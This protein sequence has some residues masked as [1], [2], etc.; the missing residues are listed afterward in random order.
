MPTRRNSPRGRGT[1]ARRP[2]HAG[3]PCV[4]RRGSFRVRRRSR[5][6]SAGPL[7]EGPGL[8]R[9]V[10]LSGGGTELPAQFSC[11]RRALRETCPIWTRGWRPAP[12]SRAVTLGRRRHL[13]AQRENCARCRSADSNLPP[14][15]RR[16]G[17]QG[18]SGAADTSGSRCTPRRRHG[19]HRLPPGRLHA[20]V[21]EGGGI[22]NR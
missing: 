4:P 13:V 17:Y 9:H 3:A 2:Y 15:G 12:L 14:C 5:S 6:S 7:R 16:R 10:S 22:G 1:V 21:G 8:L 20:D 18:S 19:G 11:G